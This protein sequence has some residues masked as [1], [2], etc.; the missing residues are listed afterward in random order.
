[1]SGRE[2]TW[3]SRPT[4]RGCWPEQCP[5]TRRSSTG[6]TFDYKILNVS[7]K[8]YWSTNSGDGRYCFVSV[9]GDDKVVVLD[10][11]SEQQVAEIPGR[12]PSAAHADGADPRDAVGG[13]PGAT[14]AAAR[15]ARGPA[16]LRIMRARV[17]GGRLDMRLR[18]A[19]RRGNRRIQ[20]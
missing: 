6:A 9:S 19:R 15:K 13:L 4:G 7:H 20:A 18:T 11:A 10:Y 8:P 2:Y 17:R 1:M 3:L 14:P 16:K 5:T 12:R